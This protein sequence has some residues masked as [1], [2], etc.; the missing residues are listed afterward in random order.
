MKQLLLASESPTRKQLLEEIGIHVKVVPHALDETS[1]CD[2]ALPLVQLAESIA[3]AKMDHVPNDL[4]D[5]DKDISFILTAD[6]LCQDK[7]GLLYGKPTNREDAVVMI[8]AMRDGARVA[9]A[10]CL[11]LRK[12]VNSVWQTIERINKV[13]TVSYTLDIP[14]HW[15]D[16][17]LEQ[18][19]KYKDIG[20]AL[21]VQYFGGQFLKTVEGSYTA[22]VGLPLYEVRLALEQI[23]FY[24]EASL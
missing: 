6:T 19:P 9:T 24:T 8:K 1:S 17:Y 10:F 4:L 5:N 3:R 12:K 21:D 15:I 13:V 18:V 16:V 11:D 20:G 7:D 22:L 14:D 23:G 2:W